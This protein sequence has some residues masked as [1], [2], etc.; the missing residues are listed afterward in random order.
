MSE[1][2]LYP[3][4][5]NI[6]DFKSIIDRLKSLLNPCTVCPRKCRINRFKSNNGFC[7]TGYKPKVASYNLHHG[8]EP[9]I[10]GYRGSGTIFFSGCP[11]RCVFCQ[12]YPISQYLHGNEITIEEL[13]D[14][15]ISLQKRGAHNINLVTPTHFVPQFVEALSIAV[16]KG[17]TIPIVYNSGG[18]ENLEVLK[19]LDGIIDIYLPDMKYGN[20]EMAKKYSGIKDY[21][22]INQ[23][24]IIEMY[25]Q[26]GDLVLDENGVAIK[27]LIIRHLVLPN[28][29]SGTDKILKF[30]ANL[31]NTISISL[32]SQYFPA[33]KAP[34]IA[35]LSQRITEKEY[36]NATSL[37]EKLGL[38]NGWIQPL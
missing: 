16:D 15:M 30:I 36:E 32:M 1:K 17:L 12:N 8:E 19:L 27:G 7:R 2:G 18:Y 5:L 28:N 34:E 35:E 24:A 11:M 31:S 9:P 13:A 4:Y 3:S 25:R 21:V 23:Q 22:K 37:M 14:Y 26:V 38:E 10:S 29:I 33:Y 6:K 20:D